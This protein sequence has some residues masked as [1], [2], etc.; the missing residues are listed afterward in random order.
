VTA[1]LRLG[2]AICGLACACG[3]DTRHGAEPR[4]EQ[5]GPVIV[6]LEPGS[7]PLVRARLDGTIEALFLL[8]SGA[9]VS[10]VDRTSAEEAGLAVQAHDGPWST[11]GA[12][13][14]SWSMDHYA[15]LA[16]IE[17]GALVLHDVRVQAL[18]FAI[19]R[20]EGWFG[21]LGRDVLDHFALLFDMEA[22]R[23][24]VLPSEST[25]ASITAYIA[26]QGLGE[27]QWGLLTLDDSTS[28]P[29]VSMTLG[30][31]EDSYDLLI[32]TGADLTSFPKP[33]LAALGLSP[34]RSVDA[35]SVGGAFSS[36]LYRIENLDW[37]GFSISVTVK[38]SE[39]EHGMVGMDILGEFVFVLDGPGRRLWLHRRPGDDTEASPADAVSGEDAAAR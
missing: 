20:S 33:A 29:T 3:A 34:L 24:H 13:G 25:Q 18:D 39:L 27:G 31:T 1:A 28:R 16:T 21:I 12:D 14:Q 5:S 23:L 2:L 26:E 36:S 11:R 32:D 22:R 8:D 17:L 4:I 19:A 7:T 15:D 35:R 10:I 38:A 30:G 6:P 9:S 37:F